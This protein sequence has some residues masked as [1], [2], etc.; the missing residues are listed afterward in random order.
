MAKKNPQCEF[1][2]NR[3]TGKCLKHKRARKAK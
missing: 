2:K 3:R 1:G